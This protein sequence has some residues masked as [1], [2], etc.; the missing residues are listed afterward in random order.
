MVNVNLFCELISGEENFHLPPSSKWMDGNLYEIRSKGN[1][2][3][4]KVTLTVYI[5]FINI[6]KI[7]SLFP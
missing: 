5:S 1:C 3:P 6:M 2:C 4:R 7:L